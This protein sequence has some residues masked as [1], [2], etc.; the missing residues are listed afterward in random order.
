MV[1][2]CFEKAINYIDTQSQ[3]EVPLSQIASL[4]ELSET[5]V[6]S[7][8]YDCTLGMAKIS[9]SMILYQFLR[10]S[11]GKTLILIKNYNTSSKFVG[12]CLLD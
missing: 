11:K 9:C 7:F 10:S 4:I 5:C 3:E 8:H 12:F 1:V 2:G 6:Q